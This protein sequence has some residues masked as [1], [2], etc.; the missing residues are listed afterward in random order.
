MKN[1]KNNP[2][3]IAGIVLLFVA[4]IVAGRVLPHLPNFAPVAAVALFL[5]YLYSRKVG[6]I[7][8]I[9]GML[10]S[11]IFFIGTYNT[12]LMVVVYASLAIPALLAPL[13]R[14]SF[15]DTSKLPKVLQVLVNVLR[16]GG[17][18]AVGS[19]LFFLTTNFAVWAF[20][21][22]YPH[23]PAGL[24]FCYEMALPF[25]RNSLMGDLFYNG[26]FFA[27]Y[28]AISWLISRNASKVASSQTAIA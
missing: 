11:D 1:I 25:L 20:S 9:A 18:S 8:A 10:V 2:F 5:S 7:A 15:A 13:V 28:F 4:I 24:L 14:K 6:L 21:F 12:Q 26:V 17:I 19:L 23:T 27:G 3:F 16:L 22:A